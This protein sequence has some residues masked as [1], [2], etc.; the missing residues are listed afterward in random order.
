MHRS[1]M[2][3]ENFVWILGSIPKTNV[4]PQSTPLQLS[5]TSKVKFMLGWTQIIPFFF[6][7]FPPIRMSPGFNLLQE[8]IGTEAVGAVV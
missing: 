2:E 6:S 7:P 5:R 1:E 4:V 8:E 3:V